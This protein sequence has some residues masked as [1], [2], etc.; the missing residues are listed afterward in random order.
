[1]SPE[2]RA[3]VAILVALA[4]V[5]ASPLNVARAEGEVGVS[6]TR[7][8]LSNGLHIVVLRDT[9]APVVSTFLNFK[10]GADDEPI[11][12]IA[13]AQEHMFFR[14]NATL[15]GAQAD[16]IAGFTGDE[17]NADTQNELTQ[18]FHLVPAQDLDLVLH[19]DAARLSGLLDSQ[20]NW[21][22][23]R[24]AIEQEVTMDN[25]K[26][27]YRLYVKL[28]HHLLA[29]T[30]YADEGLGTLHSF[31]DQINSPQLRAFEQTWYHPNNA[32]Y[33]IAGDV[34]PE[35][36]IASVRSLFGNLP[37]ASLPTHHVGSLTSLASATFS[38]VSDSSTT[39][40]AVAYRFPGY[41]DPDYAASV[42]LT[43]ILNSQ[44]GPLAELVAGGKAIDAD[45]ETSIYPK[46]GMIL[47][48]SSVPIATL[49]TVAIRNLRDIVERY[50]RN[51]VPAD[52]VAAA[53]AHEVAQLLMASDSVEGLAGLWSGTLVVENREPRQD[54]TAIERVDAAAV[55]RVVRKWMNNATAATAYAVPKSSGM[56]SSEGGSG[57]ESAKPE[58]EKIAPLPSWAQAALQ[59]LQVPTQ[60][61]APVAFALRNGLRVIVQRESASPAVAVEGIILNDPGLQEPQGQAGVARVVE[62]LLPFGTKTYGR[63]EYQSQL[64]RISATASSGFNFSLTVPA[65]NFDR[66][67][68]LLADDELHPALRP[69]DLAVVKS[70]VAA[71]LVG[72][73]QNPD[74]LAEVA[75]AN[76]LWPPGDPARRFP[77]AADVSKL[78]PSEV[79]GFYASAFRPDLTTVAIVG[80]VTPEQARAAVER[81]FGSWAASGPRPNV[82]PSPVS[83]NQASQ[84]GVPAT[85]RI[86]ETVRMRETVG[87]TTGSDAI[88]PLYIANTVLSGDFSSMFY[89]DLRVTTGYVYY[90][91]SQLADGKTRSTFEISYG[92]A[93]ENVNKARAVA[94]ADL[95]R[96]QNEPIDDER[97]LRAKS[98]LISAVPIGEQSYEGLAKRLAR[99]G[100][101]DLPM[102][103][104][105]VMTRKEYATTARAV[106]AAVKQW[107]RPDGFV[108]IIE[109]PSA[110]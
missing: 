56:A 4:F 16:E 31:G 51:G 76:G 68:Q 91:T 19:V 92:A 87:A 95:V 77:R 71:D 25:S 67:L 63:I 102:D 86:Q 8:T 78:T 14:D 3:I 35:A 88:A 105:L 20:A 44:R 24:G 13:H 21:N 42:V 38:D 40:A 96:L 33:V 57:D 72:D 26:A 10:V 98:S 2:A 49:P 93:P 32:T 110:H 45:A 108:T 30:V 22:I 41:N 58:P 36:V 28:L 90:V 62:K 17:D 106:Q 99:L 34:E 11:T 1:M 9:L 53:K 12:G 27:T 80:D 59:G 18:Y 104:D 70:E 47:L 100:S 48:T 84:A 23:E 54:V 94:L 7:A 52:L 37:A 82:Y 39:W 97:L 74:H 15:S 50:R 73:E 6:V 64:D 89:R 107:I 75:M 85:S 65:A 29:G 43:D 55:Y 81:W 109:G 69:A 66:G 101:E 61:I 46:A 103:E 5:V 79:N 83:E 60:T